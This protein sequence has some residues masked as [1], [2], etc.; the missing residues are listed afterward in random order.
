MTLIHKIF[1]CQKCGKTFSY[2]ESWKSI[3]P[4][5]IHRNFP[6]DGITTLIISCI[7]CSCQIIEEIEDGEII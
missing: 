6:Y 5:S 4:C 2:E 7:Y 1:I 3:C